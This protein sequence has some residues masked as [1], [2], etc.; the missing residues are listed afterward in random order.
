MY[1]GIG[2][3]LLVKPG[4]LGSYAPSVQTI[5][6][7]IFLCYGIFRLYIVI[8]RQRWMKKQEQEHEN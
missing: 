6:G 3:Y 7:A 8:Q 1:L 4:V 2:L 5:L